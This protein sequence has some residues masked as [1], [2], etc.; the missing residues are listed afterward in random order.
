MS[1]KERK[2]KGNQKTIRAT[3]FPG[4]KLMMMATIIYS[5]M[6]VK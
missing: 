5:V 3:S 4:L 2:N 6:M 1:T